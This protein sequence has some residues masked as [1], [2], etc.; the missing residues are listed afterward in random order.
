VHFEKCLAYTDNHSIAQSALWQVDNILSLRW[1][2]VTLPIWVLGGLVVLVLLLAVRFIWF[3]KPRHGP[4]KPMELLAY[5]GSAT[6]LILLAL[7][8]PQISKMKIAGIEL[9]RAPEINQPIALPPALDRST[10]LVS[11]QLALDTL[12][13]QFPSTDK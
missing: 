3:S 4:F 7:F 11:A 1:W 9:E 2:Q 13:V 5:L 10:S 8:L 6:G 12:K